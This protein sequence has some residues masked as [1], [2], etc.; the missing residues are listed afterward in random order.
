MFSIISSSPECLTLADI[1]L[2]MQALDRWA[3]YGDFFKRNAE[4][5]FNE[6]LTSVSIIFSSL[7]PLSP[8]LILH[9]VLF[10]A[11]AGLTSGVDPWPL[12]LRHLTSH[13]SGGGTKL[14]EALL[15][16]CKRGKLRDSSPQS[17]PLLYFDPP[18]C[19][20][21]HGFP[22][23]QAQLC[24]S[25]NPRYSCGVIIQHQPLLIK[26]MPL[27]FKWKLQGLI[28]AFILSRKS[29]WL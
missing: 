8:F 26:S 17:L 20:L 13:H 25:Y 29:W 28:Q 10:C 21:P 3:K 19:T 12:T 23:G 7:S 22:R 24:F 15:V 4:L 2:T 16:N 27:R 11:V 18:P 6:H 5:T 9:S 1:F 14:I